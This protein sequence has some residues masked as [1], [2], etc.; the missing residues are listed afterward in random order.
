MAPAKLKRHFTTNHCHVINKS[1]DY[2]KRQ[3][4]S[5][6]KQSTDLISKIRVREKAHEAICLAAEFIEQ[7]RK[8]HTAGENLILPAGKI[9]VR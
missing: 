1:A 2:S 3:L 4:K 8:S 9:I 6:K 7:K 5:L